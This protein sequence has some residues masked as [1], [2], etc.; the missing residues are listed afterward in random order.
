MAKPYFDKTRNV[1]LAQAHITLPDGRKHRPS[2]TFLSKVDA[3]NWLNE[4]EVEKESLSRAELGGPAVCTLAQALKHYGI[5]Y[6][7]FT[8]SA[9][10]DTNR[11]N[12][13]L[14]AA[15]M[16]LLKAK[17]NGPVT[18]LQS[19]K[20][21]A[22]RGLGNHLDARR[23]KRARVEEVIA[24]IAS[25]PCA[26]L[27]KTHFREL[28][29]AMRSAGNSESTIQKEIALIRAMFNIAIENWR[30]AN[31]VNPA[32][33]LK[34][35][36]SNSRMILVTATDIEILLAASEDE[37]NPYFAKVVRFAMYTCLRK[38]SIIENLVW[39]NVDIENRIVSVPTKTSAGKLETFVL[40]RE[41]V[42]LLETLPRDSEN[43]RV[44]KITGDAIQCAWKR[45]REK[46][47]MKHLQF[48]DLRHIG[49][50]DYARRGMPAPELAKILGHADLKM[51][52][53]YI[54]LVG[55][56]IMKTLDE[57]PASKQIPAEKGRDFDELKDELKSR[58]LKR[59]G[60]TEVDKTVQ[61]LVQAV[62]DERKALDTKLRALAK[63]KRDK[64][65]KE[66]EKL[67]G[68]CK[69]EEK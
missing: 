4:Q 65:L 49:A 19:Y 61:D 10:S 22:P 2:K 6:K 51:A 41:A 3:Q 46:V 48:R 21:Q 23:A 44:F 7:S 14:A 43:G 37:A 17:N 12:H 57:L 47:G 1:W 24:K 62:L 11:I 53:R 5:H 34:L 25:M 18:E 60:K 27:T 42:E 9:G 8:G 39:S 45:T 13:Y 26:D 38:G 67:F 59:L 29:N 50:T 52:M 55:A 16:P 31:F 20:L 54:N 40:S 35:G 58:S 69:E 36:G 63:A 28:M 32:E 66:V 64:N 33:K 68:V 15:N 56:D 30:W